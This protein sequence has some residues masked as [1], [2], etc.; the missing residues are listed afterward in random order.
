M[1]K[2]L[3]RATTGFEP[4]QLFDGNWSVCHVL[5]TALHDFPSLIRS[6]F[7]NDYTVVNW[8]SDKTVNQTF[9]F[10]VRRSSLA[11]PLFFRFF[12][13]G[14]RPASEP[15][16]ARQGIEG[17]ER[18]RKGYQYKVN[19][20]IPLD[21]QSLTTIRLF[22]ENRPSACSF[23]ISVSHKPPGF[24]LPGRWHNHRIVNGQANETCIQAT[25]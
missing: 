22:D 13:Q 7:R 3:A 23:C 14:V 1:F 25:G 20:D 5:V 11:C 9:V 16:G 10:R 4:Y 19:K 18:G 2:A 24:I 6:R 17:E 12:W 8:Q 15:N 21:N